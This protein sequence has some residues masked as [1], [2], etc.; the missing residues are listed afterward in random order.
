[1]L[2]PENTKRAQ[3]ILALVD[4]VLDRF[5]IGLANNPQLSLELILSIQK[6]VVVLKKLDEAVEGEI[7]TMEELKENDKEII[8]NYFARY[9]EQNEGNRSRVNSKTV[10][11][12]RSEGGGGSLGKEEINASYAGD[13]LFR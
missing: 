2:N 8:R 6:L 3:R 10:S 5:E 1:M 9:A 7:K 4:K 11:I 13:E 12:E